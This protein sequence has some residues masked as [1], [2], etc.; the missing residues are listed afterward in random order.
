VLAY[1]DLPHPGD[2]REAADWCRRYHRVT[3]PRIPDD[4]V[5]GCWEPGDYAARQPQL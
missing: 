2:D 4:L 1:C 3:L 5:L